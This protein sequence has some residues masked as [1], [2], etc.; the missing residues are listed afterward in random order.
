MKHPDEI[1]RIL[2]KA[3][4]RKARAAE[5]AA[6]HPGA[7]VLRCDPKN[8]T[9]P[10]LGAAIHPST[11]T[12]GRWQVSCFDADGF[13]YD[14]SEP[15]YEAAIYEALTG[16]YVNVDMTLLDRTAKTAQFMG[17]VIWSMLPD[18]KKWTTRLADVRAE[19]AAQ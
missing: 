11:R 18:A 13:A 4:A 3:E 15:T 1:Q 17:G 2:A 5:L 14:Y 9:R 19:L 8:D 7:I 12:A 16:G 10:W 6:Q